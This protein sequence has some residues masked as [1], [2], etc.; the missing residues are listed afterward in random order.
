VLADIE[1]LVIVVGQSDLLVIVTQLKI[2]HI[3]IHLHRSLIRPTGLLSLLRLL[4]ELLNLFGTLL[5]FPGKVP[6]VNL[7]DEDRG[8][9]PVSTLNTQPNLLQDEFGL[10]PSGHRSKCLH[11]Q[12][13]QNVGRGIEVA[14]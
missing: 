13:A 12:L 11:L 10:F 3:V 7:A 14:L 6:L 1:V 8:L 4:L 5:W 2:G 9:C